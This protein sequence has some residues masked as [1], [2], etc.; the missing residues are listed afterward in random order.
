M[1]E[2]RASNHEQFLSFRLGAEV[3]AIEVLR[4]RE[5]LD[6]LEPTQVP[7]MPDEILGV[8]NL[9]GKVVPVVD[10][11]IK[12]GMQR[13]ERTR[14]SCII[15]LEVTLNGEKTVVG[16]VADAV[17][18]VMNLGPDQIE[19]PP[20]MGTRLKSEFISGM[21]KQRDDEFII[22]LNVD[23][24]FSTDELSLMQDAIDGGEAS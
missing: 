21:G 7:Q 9:R 18:E 22:L 2:R 3:F 12:F 11:R 10:L 4:A 1:Q 20:K 8:I 19:P 16:A 15:I 14:E 23:R 17:K 13:S 6:Y 5:I 24:I